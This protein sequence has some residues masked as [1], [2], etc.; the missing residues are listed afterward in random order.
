M[1]DVELDP[2]FLKI[3]SSYEVRGKNT[4]FDDKHL[5]FGPYRTESISRGG[6][7]KRSSAILLRKKK[8]SQEVGLSMVDDSGL[9]SKSQA[10]GV[11]SENV[12]LYQT[13]GCATNGGI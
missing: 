12:P 11:V 10:E 4:V 8:I 6:V 5:K 9:R 7:A 3:A 2:A 13:G 1:K